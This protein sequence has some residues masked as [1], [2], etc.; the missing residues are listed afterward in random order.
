MHNALAIYSS[1]LFYFSMEEFA[2]M[3]LQSSSV[4]ASMVSLE[5]S[6][7]ER[8]PSVLSARTVLCV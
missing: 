2:K 8:N 1:L 7:S 5:M 4:V 3:I 6:V